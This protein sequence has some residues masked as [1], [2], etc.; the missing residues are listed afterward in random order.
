MPKSSKTMIND[1]REDGFPIFDKQ[2]NVVLSLELETIKD[3]RER[4]PNVI[5]KQPYCN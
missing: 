4:S 5:Q 1:C 3:E 2:N